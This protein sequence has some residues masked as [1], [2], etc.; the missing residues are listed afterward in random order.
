MRLQAMHD[1]T[2]RLPKVKLSDD[3]P[4]VGDTTATSMLSGAVL[5]AVNEINGFIEL[6][7][8]RYGGLNVIFTGGDAPRLEPH[9]K[10]RIFARPNAVPEGLQ[11]ILQ[12]NIGAL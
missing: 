1:Y 11:R 3:V 7:R 9:L 6:Y 8:S 2:A 12:H 4:L 5:G 10:F